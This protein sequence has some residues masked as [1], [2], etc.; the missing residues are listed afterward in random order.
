MAPVAP[1]LEVRDLAKHF[2]SGRWRRRTVYALDGVSFDLAPGETLGIMGESGCGKSTLAR[3]VSR[4]LEPTA[5]EMRLGSVD[6][7]DARGEQLRRLR[8]RVQIVFQDAEGTLDP[9]MRVRQLLVEPLRAH[10]LLDGAERAVERD[11]LELVNL[12]P[13]LLDRFPHELSGGQRQRIGLARALSLEPEI[14]VADEPA[15]SLDLSVQAQLLDLLRRTQQERGISYL[16]I[17]HNLRVLS[18][19][20]HRVGV[21]YLGRFVEMGPTAQVFAEPAHPYTQ[22]LVK[23]RARRRTGSGR[24]TTLEGE[25]P[26]P[27]D[28]PEGCHFNPRCPWAE[29]RCRQ[30]SPVLQGAGRL[31]SCHLVDPGEGRRGGAAQGGPR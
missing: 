31:V 8:R 22:A 5:G 11:L 24:L 23:A 20:A 7:L 19:L 30:S 4:L 21:M 25:P 17:T 1:V 9:R 13:D 14:V 2:T 12:T 18:L 26:N 3:V 6:L 28:R 27:I 10:G 15:A 16:L 29:D